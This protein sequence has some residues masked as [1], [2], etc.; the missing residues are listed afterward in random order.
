MAGDEME[1]SPIARARLERVGKFTDA[2]QK[3]I[4]RG[5]D[6]ETMLSAYYT[7]TANGDGLWQAAKQLSEKHG[8][9]IIREAQSSILNTLKLH[10]GD[11]DFERRR[12]ALLALESLKGSDRYSTVEMLL[13]SIA[14]VRQRFN[15]VTAQAFEQV[16]AQMEPQLRAQAE[17]AR[18]QGMLVDTHSTVEASIKGSPEWRNFMA[19]HEESHEQTLN[20]YV[21]RIS[22][23][24]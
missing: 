22:G 1:L 17:Q 10:T 20:D 8:P 13:G 12:A 21:D 16:K 11:E 6:V 4:Q 18:M 24:L 23:L 2:Q 14:S 19:Q 5:H 3:A 7:G 9:D 15:E